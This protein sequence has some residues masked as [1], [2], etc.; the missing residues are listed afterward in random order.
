M[1]PCH[2]TEPTCHMHAKSLGEP[3]PTITCCHRRRTITRPCIQRIPA[4]TISPKPACKCASS[5]TAL[6]RKKKSQVASILHDPPH[7]PPFA[8]SRHRCPVIQASSRI[9]PEEPLSTDTGDPQRRVGSGVGFCLSVFL[10]DQPSGWTS[11]LIGGSMG[12]IQG[13]TRTQKAQGTDTSTVD[14]RGA[15]LNDYLNHL[16]GA[17]LPCP[18]GRNLLKSIVITHIFRTW[19]A[20]RL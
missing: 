18:P 16:K 20:S 12:S 6:S 17:R 7:S 19:E 5:Q 3:D 11:W 10:T 13:D 1:S 15:C 9:K 14:A 8:A 4:S 2:P